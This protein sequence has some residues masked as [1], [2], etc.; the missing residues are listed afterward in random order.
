MK[1]IFESERI[2]YVKVTKELVTEYLK[3]INDETIQQYLT[4]EKITVKLNEELEWITEKLKNNA[5]I[6]S[7]IEKET[8]EFI[9]NIEILNIKDNIGELG[10]AITSKKQNKHYGQE[11]IKRILEYAKEELKLNIIDLNVYSINKRGI[12]CYEKLGFKKIG[13]GKELDDIRM[14]KM[15]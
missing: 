13:P 8:N 15:L 3:M 6:F 10:I 9:G 1:K 12:H 11:S 5:V 2:K 4:H 14:R 7:M